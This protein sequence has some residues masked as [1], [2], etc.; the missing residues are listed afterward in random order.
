M[1]VATP[2]VAD[3]EAPEPMQP[4]ERSFNDPAVAAEFLGRLDALAGDPGH[5]AAQ[6]TAEAQHPI[7]VGLVGMELVRATTRPAA[8]A[9]DGWHRI[10]DGSEHLPVVDIGRRYLGDKRDAVA[11]DEHVILRAEPAA[12]GRVGPGFLAPLFAGTIE[13]SSEARSQSIFSA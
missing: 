13:V 12:V 10:D 11:V 1:N 9:P 3:R 8:R 5:D 6:T 2:L 7:V 4:G